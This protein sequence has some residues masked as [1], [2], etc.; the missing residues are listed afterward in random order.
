MKSDIYGNGLPSRMQ[1]EKKKGTTDLKDLS[2]L[3]LPSNN[4]VRLTC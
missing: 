4:Q 3:K 2:G 1:V